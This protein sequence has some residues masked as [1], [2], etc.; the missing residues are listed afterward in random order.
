MAQ[1]P[2]PERVARGSAPLFE[3]YPN[4]DRLRTTA[5]SLLDDLAAPAVRALC[6]VFPGVQVGDLFLGQD[7]EP[8]AHRLELE[9]R[10]FMIQILGKDVDLWIE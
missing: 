6:S 1:P 10:H 9:A 2:H 4:L 5:A 8:A 3:A 7:L